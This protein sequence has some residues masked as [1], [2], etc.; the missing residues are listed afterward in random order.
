MP[1]T[2]LDSGFVVPSFLPTDDPITSFNKAMMF[3]GQ[4]KAIR[5]GFI[6]IVEDV[7]ADHVDAF[8]SDYDEAPTSSAIFMARLSL[9][10]LGCHLEEIHVTWAHSGK[11]RTRLQLYTKVDEEKPYSGRRQRQDSSDGVRMYKRRHQD[12]CDGNSFSLTTMG[13][14]HPIHTLGDYSRASHKG[15]RN[16]IKLPDGNNV[17]PLRSNTIWPTKEFEAKYNKVKAKL[18]LLSSSALDFKAS[19]VKNTEKKV[20]EMVNRH[21]TG[22]KSYLHKYVEQPGPKFDEKRGTIFNSN[23]EIVM[24][25]PRVRVVYV[26]DMT[27]SAQESCFFAKASDNLN[28][29]WH[30]RLSHLNFVE[31]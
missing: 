4:G 1:S 21:M 2:Q 19:M 16:T 30:K 8:D 7:K 25:T 31:N 12:S 23:K 5:T 3:L 28:W 20:P 29:L 18:A 15:Y 10:A 9:A 22:V 6:N 17:V 14:E 13:D 26:L 11:K 24:I 27:S